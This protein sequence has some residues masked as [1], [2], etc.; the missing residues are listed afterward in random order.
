MSHCQPGSDR[1]VTK[2]SVLLLFIM[3]S[4]RSLPVIQGVEETIANNYVALVSSR[5][6]RN[7]LFQLLK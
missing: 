3:V 2:A 4:E 1:S 6:R 5:W 7:R